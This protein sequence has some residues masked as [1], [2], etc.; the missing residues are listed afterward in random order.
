MRLFR[1]ASDAHSQAAGQL[2]IE[3]IVSTA[4]D[5]STAGVARIV[6]TCASIAFML[7][8]HG[9]DIVV[10]KFTERTIILDRPLTL[11]LSQ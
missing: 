11:T 4:T 8:R 1:G 9:R 6:G 7:T 5:A 3:A 2:I 10:Q